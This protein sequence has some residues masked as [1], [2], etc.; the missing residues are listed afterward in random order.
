MALKKV[1]SVP[2]DGHANQWDALQPV[3]L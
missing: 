1:I 3:D 2:M